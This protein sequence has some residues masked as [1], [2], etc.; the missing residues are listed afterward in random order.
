MGK[1]VLGG[2]WGPEE[3]RKRETL[4]RTLSEGEF[5]AETQKRV[6]G[7]V[8]ARFPGAVESLLPT[9]LT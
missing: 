4:N 8:S 6:E 5:W 1:C 2:K 3:D 7:R 9:N